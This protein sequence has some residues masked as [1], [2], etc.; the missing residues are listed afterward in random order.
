MLGGVCGSEI[1]GML[2]D[3]VQFN[4]RYG[5]RT[6]DGMRLIYSRYD[7]SRRREGTSNS[8]LILNILTEFSRS[9]LGLPLRMLA[10]C[11]QIRQK[12][13]GKRS[14]LRPSNSEGRSTEGGTTILRRPMV[15]EAVEASVVDQSK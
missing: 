1:D 7:R 13:K 6:R 4:L 14:A 9:W 12:G 2:K 5:R 15:S 10:I 8:D 11:N 3:L